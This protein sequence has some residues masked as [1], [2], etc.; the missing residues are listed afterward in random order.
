MAAMRRLVRMKQTTESLR[1]DP[2]FKLIDEQMPE[3]AL[4]AGACL[5]SRKNR[6]DRSVCD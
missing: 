6:V 1:N 4:Q 5:G 2:F 3:A